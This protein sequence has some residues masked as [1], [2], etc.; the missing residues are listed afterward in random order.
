MKMMKL[1]NPAFFSIL[2]ILGCISSSCNR[3]RLPVEED[4]SSFLSDANIQP[5]KL[6]G[7]WQ[8]TLMRTDTPVDLDGDGTGSTNLLQ[9]TDC[10]NDMRI[11]FSEDATFITQNAQMDF[12][13]GTSGTEFECLNDRVDYG[14]WEI[15]RDLLILNI[16]IDNEIYTD[17]KVIKLM[18]NRFSFEVTKEESEIYVNDPG[19]TLVSNVQVLELEYS[20][21]N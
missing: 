4:I 18:G 5:K 9:E 19:N 15:D 8:L 17:S 1:N 16:L 14:T 10:Y 13:A 12:A 6:Y 21:S 7:N 3:T 2:I 11:E 20:R